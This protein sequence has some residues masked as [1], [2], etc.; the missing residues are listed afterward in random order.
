MVGVITLTYLIQLKSNFL[1]LFIHQINI[2]LIDY[3]YYL[4]I[5]QFFLFTYTIN[6]LI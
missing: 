3:F 4:L 5:N 2:K 1:N 6:Y